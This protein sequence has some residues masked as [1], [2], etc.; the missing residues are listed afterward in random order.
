[1][2]LTDDKKMVDWLKM[3]RFNGKHLDVSRWEDK[4]EIIGW[5]MYM[6]PEQAA[7]GLSLLS[8][9]NLR[10]ENPDCGGYMDYPDLSEQEVF[11]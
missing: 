11:K 7:R 10:E 3:A 1:M 4:F 6:T 2:V 8:N 9:M 5:D